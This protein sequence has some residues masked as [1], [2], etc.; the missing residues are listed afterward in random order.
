MPT[1]HMPEE[2]LL[3]YATGSTAE[4]VSLA[5]ACHASLCRACASRIEAL[6]V[7]GGGM[8]ERVAAAPVAADAFARV[9]ARMREEEPPAPAPVPVV[10]A[11][12][13][14]WPRPLLQ[15]LGGK[16]AWQGLLPG[17][18]HIPLA[19]DSART[20]VVRI[21]PGMVIPAHGH[22]GDE[23]TVVIEGGIDDAGVHYRRGDVGVR[24]PG[25]EHEQRIADGEE[26]VALVVNRGPMLPRTFMGRL[27]KLLARE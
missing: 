14:G 13:E 11:G 9:L 22:A 2:V 10:P 19:V 15:Y 23:Y 6:E 1:Q 7:V 17:L 26:C 16:L 24:R 21:R 27:L 5:V 3:E 20:R 8:L 12:A 18:R 25:D 4:P